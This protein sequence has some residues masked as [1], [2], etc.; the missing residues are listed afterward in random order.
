MNRVFDWY[1]RLVSN[2]LEKVKE[3]KV[4]EESLNV[5]CVLCN[6]EFRIITPQ[7]LKKSHNMSM[8]EY[9]TQF[10]NA[11][12]AG[13]H[14]KLAQKHRDTSLFKSKLKPTPEPELKPKVDEDEIEDVIYDDYGDLN[15]KN[16][17]SFP[18]IE[19]LDMNK[20]VQYIPL[21]DD[22]ETSQENSNKRNIHDLLKKLYP[23]VQADYFVQK[24]NIVKV[25]LYSFIT[26]FSDPI[27]KL[28]F[29]FPE[30]FW[31]NVE[32]FFDVNKE[33]KL[34][35]DGWTII[36]IPG[37]KPTSDDIILAIESHLKKN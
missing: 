35:S 20:E 1:Q 22:S 10:P 7:H 27:N 26:D 13:N 12:L 25:L 36:N 32:P 23:F 29:N 6:R 34:K 37:D 31:H 5:K 3:T 18:E 19:E 28:I 4:E 33:K 17:E 14:F 8:E 15:F 11:P 2:N 21:I 16:Q 30:T 24:F 9:K